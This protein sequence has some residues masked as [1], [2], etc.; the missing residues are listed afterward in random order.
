M[1]E[2]GTF[3]MVDVCT[4]IFVSGIVSTFSG[5]MAVRFTGA[6]RGRQCAKCEENATNPCY[7]YLR[8]SIAEAIKF[9]E[10]LLA[11]ASMSYYT[12]GML[13]IARSPWRSVAEKFTRKQPGAKPKTHLDEDDNDNGDN[14]PIVGDPDTA[15]G[16]VLSDVGSQ[17][18]TLGTSAGKTASDVQLARVAVAVTAG[19][20]GRDL[21]RKIAVKDDCAECKQSQSDCPECK[22][23]HNLDKPSHRKPHADDDTQ[24]NGEAVRPLT[25]SESLVAGKS[26]TQG[27]RLCAVPRLIFAALRFSIQNAD[28]IAMQCLL[29]IGVV[30]TATQGYE[31][32]AW[33]LAAAIAVTLISERARISAYWVV[34]YDTITLVPV[35]TTCECKIKQ[36]NPRH[37]IQATTLVVMYVCAIG[38]F[39]KSER[40]GTLVPSDVPWTFGTIFFMTMHQLFDKSRIHTRPKFVIDAMAILILVILETKQAHFMSVPLNF[41]EFTWPWSCII[42]AIISV[43][44]TRRFI[45]QETPVNYQS[46]WV[47]WL[48]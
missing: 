23:Q 21:D 28:L 7:T 30:Y 17:D 40:S 33:T 37:L 12:A 47:D 27:S 25:A 32:A 8:Y 15:M 48:I 3:R 2:A 34:Q 46:K 41:T 13:V 5:Y 42:P 24:D 19:D 18:P 11:V 43:M 36:Q 4:V 14:G 10:D 38:I 35:W 39:L 1:A 22:E 6:S 26:A 16:I 45:I 44:A 20:G 29:I 31:K 9:G